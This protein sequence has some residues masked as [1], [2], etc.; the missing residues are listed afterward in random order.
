MKNN[1]ITPILV[2]FIIGLITTSLLALTHELTREARAEQELARIN[3]YR[4]IL[5]PLAAEYVPLTSDDWQEECP[6]INEIYFALDSQGNK[7]GTLFVASCR[8]YAGAVPVMLAIDMESR[9]S[10][11]QVLSNEETPGLGK[12]V[13]ESSFLGQFIGRSL[14]KELLVRHDAPDE[15]RIDAV[16]GA[17]IS[18]RAVTEAANAVADIYPLLEQ[19]VKQ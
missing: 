3:E 10:G 13:E 2:L 11:I 9:I 1:N 5:Y 4:Q 14:D 7:L 19:E 12:K 16:S 15:Q 18:S 17:T 8:G 6:D